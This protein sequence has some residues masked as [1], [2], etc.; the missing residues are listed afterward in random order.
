MTGIYVALAF[1]ILVVVFIGIDCW[2]KKNH[3]PTEK[4]CEATIECC[5]TH[6][7]CEK[8]LPARQEI[9]Y[10]DDEEL[11]IF[12]GRAGNSYNEEEICRFSDVFYTLKEYDVSG[13]LKSLQ[14]RNIELPENLRE[15]ALLIAREFRQG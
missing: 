14:M 7:I 9:E 12:V 3:I 1:V 8:G 13:W 4:P 10:Y 2:R 11:D 15:E 5:G 6:A